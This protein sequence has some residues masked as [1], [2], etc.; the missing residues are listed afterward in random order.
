M[1]LQL[2]KGLL[3]SIGLNDKSLRKIL[4]CWSLFHSNGSKRIIDGSIL[5]T[6]SE[7]EE[8]EEEQG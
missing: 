5:L 1:R 7:E 3:Q 2:M 6:S 8:E 4:R